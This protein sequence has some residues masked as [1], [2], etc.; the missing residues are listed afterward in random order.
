MEANEMLFQAYP[1]NYMHKS[2]FHRWYSAFKEWKNIHQE[3]YAT[4]RTTKD[5]RFQIWLKKLKKSSPSFDRRLGVRDILND[6]RVVDKIK[7]V[8]VSKPVI[9]HLVFRL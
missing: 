3:T 8:T 4:F 9:S 5:V 2:T 7:K 6:L 1:L